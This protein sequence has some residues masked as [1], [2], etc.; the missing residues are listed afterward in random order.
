MDVSVNSK[1][2]RIVVIGGGFG[3]VY[4]ATHLEKIF[5][6]NDKVEII[7]ISE[8]NYLL[9]TPML[10]E[11][12]SSSIEAKHM[13]NPIRACLRETT[14][15]NS[16]VQEIDLENK[17]ITAVHCHQCKPF[18]IRYDYLVLAPGS[19]TNFY[20][21]PGVAEHALPMKTLND[22]MRL[23]NHIIYVLEHADL[24][25][26]DYMRQAMLTFVVVGGGFAGVET[27][28]ELRDFLDT[29]RHYYR[30]I[31]KDEMKV[32][33]IHGGGRILPELNEGLANYASEKLRKRDIELRLHTKVESMSGF[34]IYLSTGDAISTQSLIWTAGVSPHTLVKSLPISH[35]KRGQVKVNEY[36]EVPELQDVWALGDCAEVVDAES[37]QPAPPTAQHAVREGKIVAENI[38][39]TLN[40][41]DKKVF[42]YKPLGI[43]ASLG[44]RSA[45]AEIL[46]F[47]FSGFFAWWLWRTIYLLKLP[48]IERKLRVVIDWTLDLFFHR[49]IVLLQSL[50][51]KTPGAPDMSNGDNRQVDTSNKKENQEIYMNKQH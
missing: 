46:G 32:V 2:T 15:R 34:E 43:L 1:K 37:G 9:F 40:G 22:A 41:E 12:A 25:K 51:D 8:Q 42:S 28:A 47:R 23:R 26:D 38:A 20:D 17:S 44:R 29:A 5:A 11:V 4:T 39:A 27:A 30:N 36:L 50:L 3:G 33:L 35:N 6:G 49:D 21:L 7:L 13:I 45:V 18:T 16:Q 31:V 48:G 19:I 14:F 10:S 24:E